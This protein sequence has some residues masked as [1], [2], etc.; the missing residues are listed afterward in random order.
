MSPATTAP[1]IAVSGTGRAGAA[2]DVMRVQLAASAVRPT[3]AAAL[4]ASEQAVSAIRAVLVGAGLPAADAATA[5]LSITA[6]QV[7]AEQTGP[8]TVGFRSEHRLVLSLRDLSDA[9]ALLG[10]ALAA[11]GDDLRLDAVAFEVEDDA[12]LRS[13]ARAAA[14][15]RAEATARQLAE[16]SGRRLG[17]VATITEHGGAPPFPMLRQAALH[18]DQERAQPVGLEPGA[19][20]VE[21]TIAVQWSLAEPGD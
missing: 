9:G 1:T 18:G 7:W 17:Q 5:G 3:V 13:R 15:V 12:E 4:A 20:D 10:Q 14:W 11:G 6:E 21:V 16:L 2:P 19:V 8:R